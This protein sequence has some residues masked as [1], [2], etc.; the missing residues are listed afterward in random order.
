MKLEDMDSHKQPVAGRY[1]EKRSGYDR[2]VILGRRK[3]IRFDESGG[4][5]RSGYARRSTD[6][7]FRN[8]E[9]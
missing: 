2:R 6:I 8:E 9:L 3:M 1:R 5:R 7:G 4:D